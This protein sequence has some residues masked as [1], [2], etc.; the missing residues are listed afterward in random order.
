M[1]KKSTIYIDKTGGS[2]Y[3]KSNCTLV[4]EHK[5]PFT[6]IDRVVRREDPSGE[7]VVYPSIM[8]DGKKYSACPGCFSKP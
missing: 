5:Y 6:S 1:N 4:L 3:H 8:V 2:R 7:F